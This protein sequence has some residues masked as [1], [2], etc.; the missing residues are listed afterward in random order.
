MSFHSQLQPLCYT[1]RYEA[2]QF[3]ICNPNPGVVA[4]TIFSPTRSNA[5]RHPYCIAATIPGLTLPDNTPTALYTK[6][7]ALFGS[8]LHCDCS[9]NS[10]ALYQY[11]GFVGE[12]GSIDL[13]I[14]TLFI[15]SLGAVICWVYLIP[16]K[17][18]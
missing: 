15:P 16:L 1:N 2:I 9:K 17:E 13:S 7:V 18:L 5:M 10:R 6:L 11:L 4:R 12:N 3:S 14:R 8:N